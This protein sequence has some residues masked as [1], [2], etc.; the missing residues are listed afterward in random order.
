MRPNDSRCSRGSADP[1]LIG[2]GVGVLVYARVTEELEHVMPRAVVRV[3]LCAC[4][5][6]AYVDVYAREM[7][8]LCISTSYR[9]GL[10]TL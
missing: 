6:H 9:K 7:Y 4:H 8:H 2:V 10:L 3:R 1:Q 5:T